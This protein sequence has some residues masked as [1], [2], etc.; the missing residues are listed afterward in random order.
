MSSAA[1][2]GHV[3]RKRSTDA[4]GAFAPSSSLSGAQKKAALARSGESSALKRT[5]S[6]NASLTKGNLELHLSQLHG[7]RSVKE[8]AGDVRTVSHAKRPSDATSAQ[9]SATEPPTPK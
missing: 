1:G 9:K 6:R 4:K 3:A 2:G 8:A 5:L 7:S